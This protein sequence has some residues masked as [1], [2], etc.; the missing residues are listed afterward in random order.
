MGHSTGY[1]GKEYAHLKLHRRGW[2]DQKHEESTSEYESSLQVSYIRFSLT[3]DLS[4][5]EIRTA[6]KL[7]VCVCVCVCLVSWSVVFSVE[8]SVICILGVRI[9][10]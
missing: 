4:L 3:L 6:K 5:K 9:I 1:G 7:C 10:F 8:W 2:R